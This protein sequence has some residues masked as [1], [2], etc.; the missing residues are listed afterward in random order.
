MLSP[1]PSGLHRDHRDNGVSP[2]ARARVPSLDEV[3]SCASLRCMP[4]QPCSRERYPV[5][6]DKMERGDFPWVTGS[7]GGVRKQ[8]FITERKKRRESSRMGHV[9]NKKRREMGREE[10]GTSLH[11][12]F[13]YSS[14]SCGP[15]SISCS[16]LRSMV[17][18]PPKG[19]VSMP[20]RTR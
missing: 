12:I 10:T 3:E 9:R 19:I 16:L 18:L 4:V 2:R 5:L 15:R 17:I 14:Q 20:E 8:K 13:P 11:S 1:L 6:C 7:E